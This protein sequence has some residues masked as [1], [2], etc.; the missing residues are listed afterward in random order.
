[1]LLRQS[2]RHRK[3]EPA[4]ERPANARPFIML[5]LFRDY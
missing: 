1:M 5:T 4:A 2:Q 3:Y